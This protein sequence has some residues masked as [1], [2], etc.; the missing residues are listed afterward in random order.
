MEFDDQQMEA[1]AEL[2]A[3]GCSQDE[4]ASM[5]SKLGIKCSRATLQRRLADDPKLREVYD[6]G[7]LTGKVRLRSRMFK[8]AQ[9]MNGAGVHQSQFL[10]KNWLGMTDRVDLNHSGKIETDGSSTSTARE[11]VTAKLESL[12]KRLQGRGLIGGR[13]EVAQVAQIT[14]RA[15]SS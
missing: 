7:V 9:M 1:I 13:A 3:M 2:A 10:A 8:Q 4:I 11:R 14:D 12:E 15:G 6:A 5:V